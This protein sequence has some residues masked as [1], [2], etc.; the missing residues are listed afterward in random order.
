ML[1]ETVP[2]GG[3]GAVVDKDGKDAWDC[4]GRPDILMTVECQQ[5]GTLTA[6]CP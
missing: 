6:Q 3:C 5:L 4:A 1:A 2:Q